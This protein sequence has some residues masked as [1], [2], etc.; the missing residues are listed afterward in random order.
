[1]IYN[2]N[3]TKECSRATGEISL[4]NQEELN[5]KVLMVV[6][7][8]C[9]ISSVLDGR[10]HFNPSSRIGHAG[11]RESKSYLT[12]GKMSAKW[13]AKANTRVSIKLTRKS[14]S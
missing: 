14:M 7:L 13:R 8:L 9:K 2:M 11:L 1:M 10:V 6:R 3:N 5:R 12:S 4:A